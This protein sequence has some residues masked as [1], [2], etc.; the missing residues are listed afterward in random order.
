MWPYMLAWFPM[1]LIAIANGILREYGYGKRMTERAAHQLSTLIGIVLF[2]IYIWGVMRFWPPA[3][4][5]LA[6]R[7]GL[8]WLVLTVMF[9]FGFGHFVAGHSWQRLLQDYNIRAGRVWP[10]ILLW[11]AFAPYLFF[12]IR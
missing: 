2:G 5:G 1:I 10:A 9:E 11:V 4:A 6:I 7:I 12:R 3:S 8:I